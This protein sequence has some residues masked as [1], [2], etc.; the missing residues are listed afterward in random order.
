MILSFKYLGMLDLVM[1]RWLPVLGL[2]LFAG[3]A[4]YLVRPP[5]PVAVTAPAAVFSA[6]RA[7]R[8][9]AVVARQPHGPGT[10]AHAAVRD[11]LLRRCRAL[12]LAA[13]VQ[14]TTAVAAEWGVGGRVQNVVA[15]LPGRAPGGRAVLV[16]VHYD[17]QPHTPGAADDGA[18]VGAALETIR[19][20]RAGPPLAHD[21]VWVFTD[22]EEAGLLGARAYA[23]DTARLR[24]TVG[25]VL[26]FEARGNAGPS[27]LF[28]VSD[29]NGWVLREFAR[30]APVPVGSSLAYELYR[31]LPNNTD[32]TVFRRAGLPGLNFAFTDGYSYYHSPADTP[33]HLD[34][35]SLQHHGSYLLALVRHFGSI[36]LTPAANAPDYTFFNPLG[37]WLVLYNADWNLALNLAAGALLLAAVV[38]ARRRGHV[39]L[40]GL[41]AGALAW[42][43]VLAL[44]LAL[45]AG[46]QRLVWAAYPQYAAFYDHTFYNAGAYHLALVALGTAGFAAAYGGLGRWLRP[47]SLAGGLLLVVAVLQ[48]L[49]QAK[50]RTSGFLLGF[51]LLFGA[52]AWLLRPAGPR[53]P[54][55]P[56]EPRPPAAPVGALGWLLALPAAA[57]MGP[58]VALLLVA[59]G[60]GPLLLSALALLALL[61][62]LLL[63]VLL[64]AL[65]PAAGRG[66]G[67]AVPALA[68]A[69]AVGALAT[70]HAHRQP[71]ADKPQQTHA[72]YL[73]DADHAQAYWLSAGAR[74]DA[75]NQ[76]LFSAPRYA[77]LPGLFPG[78]GPPVLY[79]AAPRLALAAPQVSVVSDS[80]GAGGRRLRLLVRPARAGVV[81]LR[82]TL[83]TRGLRWVRLAG[84]P[85]ALAG[86]AGPY[87]SV[88]FYAPGPAGVALA[89]ETSA[90]GPLELA[91]TD[92]S[93]GLPPLPG[94]RPL[95]PTFVA[96]PG[97]NSFTT[98]VRKRFRL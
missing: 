36:P 35:A 77:P 21:V 23:A 84:Q 50:A 40:R 46:G 70:A 52:L 6:E 20:L 88:S 78:A 18:G 43:G 39:R 38:R 5:R 90:P 9:V 53:R 94:L 69:V 16:A 95:P 29:H 76:Q 54:R 92:R 73:L 64:P 8:E 41:L 10:P 48:M 67:W 72:Y 12:G 49:V 42:P 59:A 85:L 17:S 13:T 3:W 37:T 61:L 2:A 28:E 96:A 83:A 1:R 82:F 7:L 22:G 93:L 65:G 44:V 62:G 4:V 19:A 58:L 91:V 86:A 27:M 30:A 75:W 26:N 11:Y 57:V 87:V 79:Q 25:V 66:R 45:G 68:G 81:S 56:G 55:R 80:A 98:Q 51:P 33:A 31:Y 89:L 15:R 71:T 34:P 60:L 24:R 32:F 14:D 47:E 74:P 97:D 63:P